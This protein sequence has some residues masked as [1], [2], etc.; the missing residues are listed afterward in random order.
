MNQEIYER[1][2]QHMSVNP[3]M[4]EIKS[5]IDQKKLLQEQN[6]IIFN[7][8]IKMHND[9]IQTIKENNKNDSLK[10]DVEV[11][12][13]K[14]P[15]FFKGLTLFVEIFSKGV[16]ESECFIEQLMKKGALITKKLCKQ[17]DYIIF[18]DGR[19]KTIEYA[20]QNEIE[21]INCL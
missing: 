17:I 10:N 1:V 12:D 15:N 9:N 6:N 3:L 20:I 18:M 7:D 11:N 2:K 21:V 5:K 13:F 19:Q 14:H 4:K 16:D 8:K